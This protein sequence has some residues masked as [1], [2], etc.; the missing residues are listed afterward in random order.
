MR[1]VSIEELAEEIRDAL[2]DQGVNISKGNAIT[3][4]REYFYYVEDLILTR[5]KNR[6]S[7]YRK[8][9]PHVFWPIDQKKLCEE[10]A[11]G[12]GVSVHYL[13]KKNKLSKSAA[14]FYKRRMSVHM[15]DDQ[16]K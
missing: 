12:E 14:K 10:F 2:A 6:L 13:I 3:L 5:P 8:D 1:D 4:T 9:I 16:L 7:M 11:S 15:H